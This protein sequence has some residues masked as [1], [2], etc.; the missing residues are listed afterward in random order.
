MRQNIGNHIVL[1]KL[2]CYT[3]SRKRESLT[4]PGLFSA[5]N[6]KDLILLDVSMSICSAIDEIYRQN[7][8][9][10]RKELFKAGMRVGRDMM[11][12]D[13]NTLIC[14]FLFHKKETVSQ[15]FLAK[16]HITI[17]RM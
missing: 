3:P 4:G 12:T 16:K 15:S 2:Q 14:A 13:S 1:Q 7:P 17:L 6:K 9:L 10:T 11:G 8:V 5:E